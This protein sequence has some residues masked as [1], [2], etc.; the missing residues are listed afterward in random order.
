MAAPKVLVLRVPGINCERETHHA[1]G[2]AGGAPEFVHVK[3]LL[4]QPELLDQFKIF[5]VPGGYAYGDD[6]ASGRVLANEIRRRMGDRMTDFIDRGGLALGICNGF[7]VLVKLG[8]LPRM[9]GDKLEQQV[10]VCHNLSNH[11]ECRWVTL[12]SQPN[13]CTFLDD[14]LTIRLPA[15]HAEGYL[16]TR[17]ADQHRL[18]DEEGYIA[19]SYVDDQGQ[20]TSD[21]PANPNGS[22]FGIAGLTDVT[23]R[24]LG[25]MPHPDRAYL[26]HHMP[27]WTSDGLSAKGDG[28]AVFEAMVRVAR[29]ES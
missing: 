4:E 12:K 23:G 29:A 2:L 13:R 7:Q 27:G 19:L 26:P 1:F 17:D 24:V 11:Y 10:T 5:M 25:L 20:K 6:I 22:P 18:L 8:L 15:A 28:M 9:G 21:Y 3:K 16:M 14:D